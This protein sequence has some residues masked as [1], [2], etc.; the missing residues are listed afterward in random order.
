MAERIPIN[1]APVLTLRAAVAGE[2]H[3][4]RGASQTSC[5]AAT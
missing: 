5:A 1:R 3:G 4:V 2:R